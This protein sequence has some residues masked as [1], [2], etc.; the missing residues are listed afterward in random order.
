ML[1]GIDHVLIAVRDLEA[2]SR[3]FAERLG[4]T[5]TPGG[6]HPGVGT[7]NAIVRFGLD[8]LELISVRDRAE[9]EASPRAGLLARFLD[10]HQ[11]LFGFAAATDDLAADLTWA[12]D[13]G[14]E[15]DG[16]NAGR[17]RRPDGSEM[18]WQAASF[19]SS[20][21]GERLPFLI[22]HGTPP[23]VR[24][25][26]APAEG[27]PLGARHIAGLTLAIRD[28]EPVLNDYE[29]LLG[30]KATTVD[31][32]QEW[33]ARRSR[34]RVGDM[35]IDLVCPTGEGGP[36]ADFLRERGDGPYLLTLG[37]EDLEHAERLLRE[38]GTGVSERTR[39]DVPSGPGSR[40]LMVDPSAL[41]GTR[42]ELVQAM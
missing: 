23:E 27:H 11:G 7:H 8:Y 20:P 2:A 6:L 3:L 1:T 37:V 15:I 38:R 32:R 13:A 35:S 34:L 30:L 16:P 39:T 14:A 21:C 33:Q 25:S 42:I 22:Q 12:R 9:A 29:C 10:A 4:L 40:T 28:L 17:R 36:I 26:W 19:R 31:P 41:L 24:L 5:V 18:T